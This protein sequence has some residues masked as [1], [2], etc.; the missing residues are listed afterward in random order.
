MARVYG[1]DPNRSIRLLTILLAL[2]VEIV[3][4][5]IVMGFKSVCRTL[6]PMQMKKTSKGGESGHKSR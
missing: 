5:S 4:A 3:R 2:I 1:E 6:L